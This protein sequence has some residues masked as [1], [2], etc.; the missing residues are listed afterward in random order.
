[1]LVCIHFIFMLVCIESLKQKTKVHARIK[2]F[3]SHFCDFT[4]FHH[5][6]SRLFIFNNWKSNKKKK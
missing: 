1:M 2:F 5:T 6:L 4:L 3:C